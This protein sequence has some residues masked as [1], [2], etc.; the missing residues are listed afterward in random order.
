MGAAELATAV[1]YGLNVVAVVVNDGALT[2]IRGA[3]QKAFEGRTLG[4]RLQNPDF[5]E[6]AQAYGAHGVQVKE[7]GK[8]KA[9]LRQALEAGRP[10]VVEVCMRERQAELVAS[11]GWLRSNPLRDA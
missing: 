4:T 11:I 6:L 1:K 3:Q 10:A 5:A 9:A 8:F 2:S 7:L